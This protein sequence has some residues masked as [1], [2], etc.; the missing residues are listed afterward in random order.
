MSITGFSHGFIAQAVVSSKIRSITY[1]VPVSLSCTTSLSTSTPFKPLRPLT[2]NYYSNEAFTSKVKSQNIRLLKL[3][4]KHNIIS[5]LK[6]HNYLLT[7]AWMVVA[8]SI[9]CFATIEGPHTINTSIVRPITRSVSWLHP[10]STCHVTLSPERP[11]HPF[12][13]NYNRWERLRV[14]LSCWFSGGFNYN[15]YPAGLPGQWCVLHIAAS[16]EFPLHSS[17]P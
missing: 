12:S 8:F 3:P 7:W 5:V 13:I 14:I 17:P 15:Y 9:R 6:T 2:I 10:T 11:G 1:S 4:L 16:E